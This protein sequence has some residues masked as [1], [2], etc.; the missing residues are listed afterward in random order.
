MENIWN[1]E[2]DRESVLQELITKLSYKKGIIL[3]NDIC[4]IISALYLSHK[5]GLP[6]V[7]I[8]DIHS[9]ANRPSVIYYD[10]SIAL[11]D[12][13]FVDLAIIVPNIL[14]IDHHSTPKG[15][16]DDNKYNCNK[17]TNNGN[18]E[19]R[20]TKFYDK[21]PTSCINWLVY[22]F[23]DSLQAYTYVQM[24]MLILSDSTYKN[25]IKY[26]ANCQ[27]WLNSFEQYNLYELARTH[28]I[29][30]NIN[31]LMKELKVYEQ[32]YQQWSIEHN[33]FVENHYN[34]NLNITRTTQSLCDD[35]CEIMAWNKVIFPTQFIKQYIENR[36]VYLKDW[37]TLSKSTSILTPVTCALQN[38][39]NGNYSE[40]YVSMF[41]H[42]L[43]QIK[44]KEV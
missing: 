42:N 31:K 40:M 17:Y 9:K 32:G 26:P 6:I 5:T 8:A 16:L 28:N 41:R 25:C 1:N 29:K 19:D 24:L 7:G 44:S 21:N 2:F 14:C 15:L 18:I 20:Y 11:S 22:L 4:G 3:H 36:K 27:S 35:I 10:D 30:E 33:C 38:V 23:G 34:I 39:Q 43:K 37:E 12:C 13:V